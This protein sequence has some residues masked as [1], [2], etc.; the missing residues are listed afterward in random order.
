MSFINLLVLFSFDQTQ[1]RK[2][3]RRAIGSNLHAQRA[4]NEASRTLS[5]KKSGL[6]LM[7]M[8]N[9][10][11]RFIIWFISSEIRSATGHLLQLFRVA[12]AL[13]CNL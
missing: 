2:A 11:I 3:S 5:R 10:E 12:R 4:F 7:T 1:N 6:R 9:S 13:H 8:P